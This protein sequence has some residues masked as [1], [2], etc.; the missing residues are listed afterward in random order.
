M[1][2]LVVARCDTR[3]VWVGYPVRF[4]RSMNE[5]PD[6]TGKPYVPT[7][8]QARVEAHDTP[9]RVLLVGCLGLASTDHLRP[10]QRSTRAAVLRN[11]TAT[12]AVAE[13]HETPVRLA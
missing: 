7:A 10:F 6:G 4:Q 12:H 5:R 9:D 2:A 13:A 8:V 11:P 3:R 1:R